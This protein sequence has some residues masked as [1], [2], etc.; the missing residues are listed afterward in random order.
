MNPALLLLLIFDGDGEAIATDGFLCVGRI[1]MQ[2]AFTACTQ[3]QTALTAT[4]SNN[5]A[6]TANVE[7][8][9]CQ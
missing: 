8:D 2:P 4:A 7:I 3:L 5:A 1:T 6:L 9:Q